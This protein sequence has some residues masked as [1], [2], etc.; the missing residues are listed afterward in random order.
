[1][2]KFFFSWIVAIGKIYGSDFVTVA[3][4]SLGSDGENL[5]AIPLL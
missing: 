2:G 4:D 3:I 5:R 1:M